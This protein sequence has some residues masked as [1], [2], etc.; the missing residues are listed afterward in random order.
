MVEAA[1]TRRD[2]RSRSCGSQVE[3]YLDEMVP[4]FSVAAYYRFGAALAR[5][6]VELAYEVVFDPR[7]ATRPRWPA[8]AG[9]VPVFVINHRLNADFVVLSYGLLRH[10]AL[11]LRGRRV[12][13]RLAARRA[14]PR[15]RELLRPA[16]REGPALPHGPRALR[17]AARRR[18]RRDRLLHRGQAHR[19][20]DACGKP[21]AGLL[22]YI[23][24][25]KR[26]RPDAELAFVPVGLNFDRV[27]EDDRFLRMGSGRRRS[28]RSSGRSRASCCGSRACSWR[29]GSGGDELAPR[30]VR[31]RRRRDRRADPLVA[32]PP[33]ARDLGP[34][35]REAR[36][37]HVDAIARELID[38]FAQ[39]SCRRSAGPAVRDGLSPTAMRGATAAPSA[40]CRPRRSSS[41]AQR[42]RPSCSGAPFRTR[43]R[44]RRAF[45]ALDSGLDEPRRGRARRGAGRVRPRTARP[46]SAT[47]PASLHHAP[48]GGEEIPLLRQLDSLTTCLRGAKLKRDRLHR[49]PGVADYLSISV[50]QRTLEVQR[51]A[52]TPG[53]DRSPKRPI[54]A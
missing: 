54:P 50:A 6:A 52:D 40:A 17:A 16:R 43:R 44:R 14:L 3:E 33:P 29:S 45:P 38:R 53:K 27:L 11:Q 2:A 39:A 12:G 20:T 46:R 18:G 22:D 4:A 35:E 41:L 32:A 31:L 5:F 9:A 25:L 1:R 30:Q 49:S 7:A 21:K 48:E 28:P 42:E 26:T 13:A 51:S 10:V 23:V 37:P 34:P 24:G 15:V 8:P 19:A 47:T 36:R